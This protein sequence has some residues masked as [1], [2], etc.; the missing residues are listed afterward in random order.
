MDEHG[1]DEMTEY[2]VAFESIDYSV[3]VEADSRLE[4]AQEGLTE[5]P[6][7][8]SHKIPGGIE[9]VSPDGDTQWFEPQTRLVAAGYDDD[10]PILDHDL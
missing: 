4:A 5:I 2:S 10:G 6:A 8:K 9:V 3:L 7:H 1:G